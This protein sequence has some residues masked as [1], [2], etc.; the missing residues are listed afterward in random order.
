MT[1]HSPL[2]R[3][4]ENIFFTKKPELSTSFQNVRSLFNNYAEQS[5]SWEADSH[6]SPFGTGRFITVLQG[7]AQFRGPV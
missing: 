3:Q 6:S 5:P 1:G 4:A 2:P 7:R